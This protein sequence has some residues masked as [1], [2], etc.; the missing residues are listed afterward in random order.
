[1]IKPAITYNQYVTQLRYLNEI[2][3]L[4]DNDIFYKSFVQAKLKY[5]SSV[6]EYFTILNCTHF[7]NDFLILQV[8][9]FF[10]NCIHIFKEYK[11]T[12]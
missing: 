10:N 3:S 4:I 12:I 8:Q 1:M 2:Q 11:K 9:N 5:L 6:E 7:S